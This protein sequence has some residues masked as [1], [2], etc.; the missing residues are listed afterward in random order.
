MK[1]IWIVL[2]LFLLVVPVI[3]VQL[4]YQNPT[5][6]TDLTNCTVVTGL[7]CAWNGSATGQ[8][9]NVQTYG[10]DSGTAVAMYGT[11]SPTTYAAATLNAKTWNFGQG[12][13]RLYDSTKATQAT[14]SLSDI[15]STINS[16]HEVVVSGGTAKLYI[17]G[18]LTATSGALAQNP[19]YIGFGTSTV[20]AAGAITWWDDFV[21][22]SSEDT[23]VLDAPFN[24]Y[25]KKD[26]VNPASSGLFNSTTN[27]LINS[28]NIAMSFSR[29]NLSGQCLVNES[30]YLINQQ[31]GTVY[32]TKYTG[33]Q[34]SGQRD[35]DFGS[36][37]VAANAPYGWYQWKLNNTLSERVAYIANGANINF[38]RTDYSI[39][40]NAT[41]TY[42]VDPAYW[43]PGTYTYRIE[44][45]DVYGTV[46]NSQN[47]ATS[48][49]S[50]LYTW[51]DADTQGVYFAEIIADRISDG[52][53]ILMNYDQATVTATFGFNG[54]VKDGGNAS[55]ISGALVNYAQGDLADNA[56]SGFDG[57]YSVS[58]FLTGIPI[59]ANVSAMG[60]QTQN[61][62]F[63][64]QNGHTISRNISLNATSQT[65]TGR[66]V[67]GIARDGIFT[68]PNS[69]TNGYGRP[70]AGATC[71]MKNTTNS[72]LYS[73]VTNNAGGYLF[74]ES[75]AVYLAS[76]RPYDLWC[77]RSGYSNS[78]NYT[79]SV[80]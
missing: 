19:S 45:V 2:G 12:I 40:D 10:A 57:N 21:Y 59:W 11:A 55:T 52:E 63:T 36:S 58:G 73:N 39:G 34:C 71:Y 74:D 54:F 13:I 66:A 67:G 5:D 77:Q 48:S 75:I 65:F 24:T 28:N 27:A 17:N 37:L 50:V 53:N 3:A 38:D 32:E 9:A 56:T 46:H 69:I 60:Y 80:P 18:I 33:T 4:N 61:F 35:F 70:I 15:T 41:I 1:A 23:T 25:M 31:T 68:S 72:E 42:L 22:G 47:I 6:Y 78:Q 7:Q 43:L 26:F 79:V 20:G 49:G 30:I 14:F 16:R 64:V 29:S 76:G 51:T 62:T 8:N 44:I